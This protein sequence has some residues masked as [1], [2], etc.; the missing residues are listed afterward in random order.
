MCKSEINFQEFV[1]FL[2][3]GSR[4]QTQTL[5]FHDKDLYP[6]GHLTGIMLF[7]MNFFCIYLP[8]TNKAIVLLTDAIDY[9][10]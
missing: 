4:D 5:M 1:F 2:H 7:I 3:V 9:P 6:L 8:R 10:T